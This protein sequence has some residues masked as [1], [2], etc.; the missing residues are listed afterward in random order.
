MECEFPKMNASPDEIS[1]LLKN[2]RKIAVVGISPKEDRP[3]HWIAAY[4]MDHGYDVVGVNPGISELF[5]RKVMKS[6]RDVPG[7]VDI[8]DIFRA[9]DAVPGIVDEAIAIKAKA[10]WMQEGIVHNEAAAKAR[11]AGLKV[12]MNKCIYKEHAGRGL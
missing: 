2:A 1:E 3:S 11:A 5:G 9:P 6:L 7:P 4:L 12:I 8:V 10:I